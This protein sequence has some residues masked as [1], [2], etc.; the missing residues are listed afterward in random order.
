MII[1]FALSVCFFNVFKATRV[2]FDIFLQQLIALEAK[3]MDIRVNVG[4]L[5]QVSCHCI[6]KFKTYLIPDSGAFGELNISR[7]SPCPF[8][9]RSYVVGSSGVPC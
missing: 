5:H 7:V 1:E 4:S 8:S 9:P 3:L 6:S 2:V